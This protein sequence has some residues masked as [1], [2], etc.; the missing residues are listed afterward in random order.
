MLIVVHIHMRTFN[1]FTH[2]HPPPPSRLRQLMYPWAIWAFTP[3]G[4]RNRV[5]LVLLAKLKRDILEVFL[6][7]CQDNGPRLEIVVVVTSDGCTCDV[8]VEGVVTLQ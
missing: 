5:L 7:R 8:I 6:A 1:L 3:A 4:L 2:T